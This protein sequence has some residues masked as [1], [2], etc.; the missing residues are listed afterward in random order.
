MF[1]DGRSEHYYGRYV[2]LEEEKAPK[3]GKVFNWETTKYGKIWYDEDLHDLRSV[4][5]EFPAI[6]FNDEVSSEK[7]LSCEPTDNDDDKVDIEH[8][9]GDLSVNPLPDLINTDIDAYAHGLNKLLETII[10]EY[11]VNI[12]KRRAFWSLNEDILKIT[13]L[14]TNTPYP[15]RK[16][17]RIR[18]CTHQRPQRKQAQYTIIDTAYPLPSDTAYLTFFPIQ[19]K[20]KKSSVETFTPN[21]K[22][23]YY[24]RI[25]NIIVNRKNAYELKGKFLDDLHNNA[26]SGTDGKDAGLKPMKITK[27]IGSM[28]G[29]RTY[30]RCLEWPTYSWRE[31]GYC[32]G[33][34]LPGACHIGNSLHYQDLEWYEALED[35]ELKDEALRNKAIMEGLINDDESSNDCWKR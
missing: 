1:Q 34:N 22:A 5:T 14:T 16:I 19:H 33:G 23:D 26:F 2:R 6:S 24:S 15:S 17:R 4:E 18:A 31:D 30:H 3:R 13:I 21:D 29:M 7:T 20:G 27:M 32:N 12:S 25:T 11:L 10:T 28:N 35:N 8:S 9:S